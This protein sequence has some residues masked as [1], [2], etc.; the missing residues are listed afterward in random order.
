[1]QAHFSDFSLGNGSV[2]GVLVVLER[3]LDFCLHAVDD[4][5]TETF[6][7]GVA[8]M[9]MCINGIQVVMMY[10]LVDHYGF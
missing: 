9:N 7:E 3:T 5:P 10:I 2:A 4:M 1:M 6:P 8:Y